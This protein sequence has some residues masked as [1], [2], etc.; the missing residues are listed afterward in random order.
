MLRASWYIIHSILESESTQKRGIVVIAD[1]KDFR[2]DQF[3]KSL[4]FHHFRSIIGILPMRIS[5]F[6]GAHVPRFLSFFVPVFKKLMGPMAKRLKVHNCDTNDSLVQEFAQCG[7]KREVVPV[8]LGGGGD[9]DQK[10]WLKN[11]CSLSSPRRVVSLGFHN[12]CS[13]V[14]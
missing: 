11:R 6:H 7:I 3:D 4:V 8:E 2:V 1:A 12:I 5:A 13:G 9:C 10:E 14:F